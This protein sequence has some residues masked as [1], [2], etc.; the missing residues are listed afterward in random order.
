MLEFWMQGSEMEVLQLG[1][2]SMLVIAI[3]VSY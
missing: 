1:N 3:K 2:E